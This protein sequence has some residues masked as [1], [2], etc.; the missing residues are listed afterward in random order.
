[1]SDTETQLCEA[2]DRIIKLEDK[3]K[4]LGYELGETQVAYA[5]YRGSMEGK[6]CMM[7]NWLER[8]ACYT[9][10]EDLEAK[11][12]ELESPWIDPKDRLPTAYT[13]VVVELDDGHANHIIDFIDSNGKWYISDAE[14]Y[15]FNVTRWMYAPK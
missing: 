13:G 7:C 2:E 12:K 1:M 8:A 15:D 3:V 4:G 11:V 14:G 6:T 5:D 10:K 9:Q